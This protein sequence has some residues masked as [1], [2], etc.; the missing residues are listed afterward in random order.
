MK[1]LTKKQQI[2]L[3]II[4][5]VVALLAVAVIAFLAMRP[6][7]KA[8][9][10][11]GYQTVTVKKAAPLLFKGTV[12]AEKTQE[13][14]LDQT[15]GKITGISVTDGQQVQGNTVL[16]TYENSTVQEQADEQSSTLAK[17]NLQ[18]QNAQQN[19]DSATARQNE[20][21][22]DYNKA[23]NN[24]NKQN[25]N[26]AEGAAKKEQYNSEADAIKQQLDG[27]KDAVLQARQALEAAN[28]DLSTT[29]EA[30]EKIKGKVSTS[31]TAGMDG[32]AYVNEKGKTDATT[33][34][35]RVVS[36]A[37]V[38]EGNVSEFDYDRVKAEQKV[39]IKPTN[40][41]PEVEGTITRVDKLP[42]QGATAQAAAAGGQA[43]SSASA[44][45]LFVVKPAQDMQYGYSVQIKLPLEE[46]R[47]PEDAI[48]KDGE[49]SF[50]YVVE[51]GKA[52]KKAIKTTTKNG[53][54]IA[55]EGLKEKDRL[56]ENPDDQLKD[57]QEVAVD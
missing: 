45:Y 22:N 7:E 57:G 28:L 35:V 38:V 34:A 3:S 11:S 15:L 18:V 56:I 54:I 43:A 50:V 5:G 26:T 48:V 51:K 27:Q 19:L 2:R 44:S 46:L 8:A 1:K 33:P 42:E 12:K 32:I 37:T 53:I 9:E 20:L 24:A 25:G 52:Q 31:V 4:A 41:D 6:K 14:Y 39:T 13:F 29:N 17:S 36:P 47:I 55:T 40:G 23:V 30:V 49:E 16:L 10:E 21:T